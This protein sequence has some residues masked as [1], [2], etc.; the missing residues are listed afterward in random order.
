[1]SI[2]EQ[3]AAAVLPDRTRVSGVDLLPFTLGHLLA[4][5]RLGSP[6]VVGGDPSPADLV[7]ALYVCS[8]RASKLFSQWHLDMPFV[9]RMKGKR[10]AIKAA[11]MPAAFMRSAHSF[12]EYIEVNTT[13]PKLWI[14]S[15]QKGVRSI[16]APELLSM[17]RK[18]MSCGFSDSEAWDMPFA[19]VR[20]E[21]AAVAEV[22]GVASFFTDRE[23]QLTSTGDRN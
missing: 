18:M 7:V 14:Q 1:V 19:R 20:W 23:R 8:T 5:Q 17:H 9:W 22:E 21:Q 12:A 13:G 15:G 10:I 4:L 11:M 6:F 2:S 16:T 3:Y